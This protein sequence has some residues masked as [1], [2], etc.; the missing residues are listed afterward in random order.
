MIIVTPES[1]EY[2]RL[3]DHFLSMLAT[4]PTGC[5]NLQSVK[6]HSADSIS[7]DRVHLNEEGVVWNGPDRL[8]D[9]TTPNWLT[10]SDGSF[11]TV[12]NVQLD[13]A[14]LDSLRQLAKQKAA[15]RDAAKEQAVSEWRAEREV[16]RR[17]RDQKFLAKVLDMCQEDK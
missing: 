2:A 16:E 7:Q 5:E 1:P 10:V 15:E 11:D 12:V 13:A 4:Y 9:P 3:V 17:D 6:R 8:T 14:D